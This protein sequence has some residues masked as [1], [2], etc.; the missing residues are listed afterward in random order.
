M[1]YRRQYTSFCVKISNS[2][3]S[4]LSRKLKPYRYRTLFPLGQITH[5][6][7]AKDMCSGVINSETRLIYIR[8]FQFHQ[9]LL[10]LG[11][12]DFSCTFKI[13]IFNCL[14][15]AIH[16]SLHFSNINFRYVFLLFLLIHILLEFFY[17]FRNILAII[18]FCLKSK[19]SFDSFCECDFFKIDKNSTKNIL[20]SS[21]VKRDYTHH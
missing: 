2:L 18:L 13:I 3:A 12:M 5:K 14:N 20:F 16:S 19:L 21:G 8:K 11:L 9:L 6:S 17:V 1:F 15:I 7:V 4:N 10:N